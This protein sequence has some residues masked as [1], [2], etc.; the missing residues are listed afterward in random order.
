MLINQSIIVGNI[1]YIIFVIEREMINRFMKFNE[2]II[3]HE[4]FFLV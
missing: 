4:R 1:N 2:G 3:E